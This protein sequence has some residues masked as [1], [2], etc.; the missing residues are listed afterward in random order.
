MR[1]ELSRHEHENA[2][3]C[4]FHGWQ[5]GQSTPTGLRRP[6]LSSFDA[7]KSTVG[8][9]WNKPSWRRP[10]WA[11]P[12]WRGPSWQ[13]SSSREPLWRVSGA[14]V[15]RER[16]ARWISLE[17]FK[18]G[19]EPRFACCIPPISVFFW[20]SVPRYHPHLLPHLRALLPAIFRPYLAIL[21]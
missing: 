20:W 11:R 12:S 19:K 4:W 1:G 15:E 18:E 7:P 14:S 3:E 9:D 5:R 21:L 16:C 13:R 17:Q 2:G 10:S 6:S 8:E